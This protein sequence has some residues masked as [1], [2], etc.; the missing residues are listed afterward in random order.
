MSKVTIIA[1]IGSNFAP[2][3]LDSAVAM[4]RVAAECGAD[5][6]KLQDFRVDNMKRPQWWKDKCRAWDMTAEWLTVLTNEA[7]SL[8]LELLCSVWDFDSIR[9]ASDYQYPAFKVAAGEISNQWLLRQINRSHSTVS[10][11]EMYGAF[12]PRKV[13]LSVDYRRHLALIPALTWLPDCAV[14]LLHCISS[15]P[16]S[17]MD[18][19]KHWDAFYNLQQYGLPFGLSTHFPYPDALAVAAACVR[20]GATAVEAHLRTEATPQDCP[21]NGP[22][23]LFP[24]EFKEMVDAIR[25]AESKD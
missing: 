25:E 22:W 11:V 13:L 8:R 18:A 3:D 7:Q 24:H 20:Y 19:E 6:V 9:H 12:A 1:E 21:D 23:A 5:W 15:Y 4:V 10:G 14:T 16:P 2:G 17:V